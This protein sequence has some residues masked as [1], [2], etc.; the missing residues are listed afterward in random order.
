M[1]LDPPICVRCKQ[2]VVVNREMY[3]VFERMHYVCF[4][5]EFEHGDRDPDEDCG[6]PGCPVGE[7]PLRYLEDVGAELRAQATAARK[8]ARE[9]PADAFAQGV[10]HGY[11]V[12][13][14]LLLQQAD[15]FQIAAQSLKLDGL[16]PD[17]DLL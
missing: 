3:D 9:N 15:A 11:Y 4:H 13:L 8:Y 17:G 6:T 1:S 10:A 14:S 7:A 2:P 12:V 5:L 16:D